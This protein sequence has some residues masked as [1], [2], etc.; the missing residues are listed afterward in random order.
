[1]GKTLSVLAALIAAAAIVVELLPGGLANDAQPLGTAWSSSTTARAS[2]SGRAA[3]LRRLPPISGQATGVA[4]PTGQPPIAKYDHRVS[5]ASWDDQAAENILV[6]PTVQELA[7]P[8]AASENL[9]S[10][11]DD[12][13]SYANDQPA[14]ANTE[15]VSLHLNEVTVRQ[16]LEMLSR[17]HGIN[18]LVG[19]TVTGTV[20]ANL[21]GLDADVA[22]NAI[23]KLCNLVAHRENNLLYIYAAT[24]YP[25]IDFQ[26]RTFPLDYIAGTDVLP[27]VQSLLSPTG[28]VFATQVDPLNN[29][30][31][32]EGIA[33]VDMPRVINRVAQYIHQIDVPPLQVMIEAHV[34]QVL[35]NDDLRHGINYDAAM[36]A[37]G[38]NTLELDV[39]G[40][41]DP[42]ASPG[43][44]A[45]L[46][47][48]DIDLLLEFLK[49]TTDS[50]TLASPR[51]MVINGQ[52]AKIQVG[53][54]I[55]YKVVTV[56]ETTAIEEVRFLNVG[57]V[58][59]VTPRISRDGRVMMRVKPK[60]SDG[61]FSPESSLPGEETREV[62]SDVLI[63]DGEGLVIGGLIQEKD[64][65]I[66]SKIPFLG[67]LHYIGRLFQKREKAKQRSEVVITLIP[68]IRYADRLDERELV[69]AERSQTRLFHKPLD[70]NFRP[71]DPPL[72]DAINNPIVLPRIY[73]GRCRHC[74]AAPCSCGYQDYELPPSQTEKVEQPTES[75]QPLQPLQP[76]L[77]LEAPPT[78]SLAPPP[79]TID[80]S[81]Q[82]PSEVRFTGQ[83][84]QPPPVIFEP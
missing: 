75:W 50:R 82:A 21:E 49:K 61:K 25:Q 69:D 11:A 37:V 72:Q 40:F 84:F 44:F 43:V 10:T 68:R 81:F 57:V 38:T 60:V 79:V 26:V 23:L 12:G 65:D 7:N 76:A 47:G 36:R 56:T 27:V 48:K 71:W 24:E 14:A 39:V 9:P 28:Q 6:P 58:L 16:A 20:T 4:S 83:G 13:H 41:A 52:T 32:R 77:P 66:Q 54:Q 55:P 29:T 22:L 78:D 35:L 70:P 46:G 1:M 17:S 5:Q 15:P 45:R 51:V 34:M 63:R 18:M 3:P 74:A 8:P 64:V 67:D 2:K 62:E 31:T 33:V 30:K 53:E 59:E 19:P 73:G 42:T 80:S